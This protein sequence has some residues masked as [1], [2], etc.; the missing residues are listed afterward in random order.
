MLYKNAEYINIFTIMKVQ[1]LYDTSESEE[2]N[3]MECEMW[4]L[5][6]FVLLVCS[7]VCFLVYLFVYF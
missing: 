2:K 4:P 3:N 6:M 1:N 5:L 7:I